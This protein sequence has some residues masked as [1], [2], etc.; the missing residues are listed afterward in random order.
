MIN[1]FSQNV[2]SSV[3]KQAIMSSTFIRKINSLNS[4][5]EGVI[6]PKR[7]QGTSRTTVRREKCSPILNF[8]WKAHLFLH[9]VNR[10][11]CHALSPVPAC[12]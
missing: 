10:S 7:A 5:A 11:V 9:S 2:R 3:R 6:Q 12:V 4:E 1:I 8:G